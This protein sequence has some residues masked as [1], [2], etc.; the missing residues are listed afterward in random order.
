MSRDCNHRLRRGFWFMSIYTAEYRATRCLQCAKPLSEHRRYAQADVD[1]SQGATYKAPRNG[2]LA[3]L[4]PVLTAADIIKR[5]REGT[6]DWPVRVSE[7]EHNTFPGG[8]W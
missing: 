1:A 4:S 6:A 7:A 8:R 2:Y 5:E 3:P